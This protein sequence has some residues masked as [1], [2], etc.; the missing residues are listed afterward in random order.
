[1]TTVEKTERTTITDYA[2]KVKDAN[3][4]SLRTV[5]RETDTQGDTTFHLVMGEHALGSYQSYQ[6]EAL[7]HVLGE[8]LRMPSYD[9][10]VWEED[11]TCHHHVPCAGPCG[12]GGLRRKR[13]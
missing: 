13:S 3:I 5:K 4:G 8:A 11:D 12:T 10:E 9:P 1:M 6:I 7:Y 2:I